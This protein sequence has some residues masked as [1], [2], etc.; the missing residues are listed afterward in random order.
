MTA[1]A[2]MADWRGAPTGEIVARATA[3]LARHG[4]DGE[5]LWDG[6]SVSFGR[7]ATL[8]FAEDDSD[9]Q[10][11]ISADGRY[12]LVADVRL[13]NR[14]E[15]QRA[16]ALDAGASGCSDSW[17]LLAAWERW[18][19]R[20]LDHLTGA[21][22]FAVWDRT[23]RRLFLARDHLGTRPL[24]FW[25][26]QGRCLFATMA[27]ALYALPDIPRA[28]DHHHL[29]AIT[30][31]LP[32]QPTSSA[33]QGVH[34]VP[35]GGSVTVTADAWRAERYWQP[36]NLPA[37]TFPRD[38]D[39]V[40]A[41]REV[42]DQAVTACMRGI[43][44]VGSHLSAG[45]DS[46]TVTAT[47]AR[48]LAAR[49]ERLTAFTAVP[50]PGWTGPS[51][52]RELGDEGPLATLVAS[53]F[54]NVEHVLVNWPERWDLNALDRYARDY[55]QP[56]GDVNNA[57]WWE[58]LHDQARQRG[59]RVMLAGGMGNQTI[60]YDGMM[61]LP[62]LLRRFDWVGF[63]R[64]V[65]G[66]R[67]G[68]MTRLALLRLILD[69]YV[70]LEMRQYVLRRFGRSDMAL[71]RLW[72]IKPSAVAEYKLEQVLRSPAVRTFA[73]QSASRRD[74]CLRMARYDASWVTGGMLAAHDID[75][76]DPTADRRLMEFCFAIPEE[77]FLNRGRKRWLLRRA[78]QGIL[79]PE[80]L[81]ERRRGRQAANWCHAANAA[82][83]DIADELDRLVDHPDAAPFIDLDRLR[84]GA[85][86]EEWPVDTIV[87]DR[88]LAE[89]QGLTLQTLAMGRFMRR[90]DGAN[91]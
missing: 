82:R 68:G 43:H 21:F 36:E 13:D 4:R 17:F 39:Y 40:E 75:L 8:L 50:P 57:G 12:V 18:Q 52:D 83:S 71:A 60:S 38:E 20:C 32:R 67:A 73:T 27:S 1:I 5:E 10:P 66:L 26:G 37:R 23:E 64:H 33:F 51:V 11:R 55:E 19:A 80:L 42:F 53:R 7:R 88:L 6:G 28:L 45:W 90:F 44:P 30:A 14:A 84:A 3:M 2:G 65:P 69:P 76:R 22:A 72:P 70:N 63:A 54:P 86:R 61:L 49:G 41:F 35:A 62:A 24:F 87:T 74:L 89:R 78:M 47:A 29:I 25:H 15:L 79:P 56:R 9:R 81:A 59:I 48:L 85:S 31:S 16:L 46:S 91:D 34:R 58:E 77:Q